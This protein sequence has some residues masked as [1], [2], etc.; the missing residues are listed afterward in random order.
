MSQILFLLSFYNKILQRWNIFLID[1]WF[2]RY[3]WVHQE[4][5]HLCD[6]DTHW[7]LITLLYFNIIH[8][9]IEA[10]PGCAGA[11]CEKIPAGSAHASIRSKPVPEGEINDRWVTAQPFTEEREREL[12]LSGYI[13]WNYATKQ[14]FFWKD[15]A[16]QSIN[17]CCLCYIQPWKS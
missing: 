9:E 15:S 8:C 16:N 12:C 10:S 17:H 2:L 4:K 13:Y 5:L 6:L 1:F 3:S 14:S 11:G 7:F